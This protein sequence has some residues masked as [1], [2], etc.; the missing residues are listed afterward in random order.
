MTTERVLLA[1]AAWFL[2]GALFAWLFGW[3]VR[4]R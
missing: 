1:G 4:R 3:W 2:T